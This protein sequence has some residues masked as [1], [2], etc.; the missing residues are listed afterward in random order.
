MSH[1]TMR[2]GH[3]LHLQLFGHGHG[4]PMATLAKWAFAWIVPEPKRSHPEDLASFGLC[5]VTPHE[6]RRAELDR[7][8]LSA[9]HDETP[10]GMDETWLSLP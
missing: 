4:N 1:F 5:E 3:F 9:S 7:L 10:R 2:V 8:S 6:G